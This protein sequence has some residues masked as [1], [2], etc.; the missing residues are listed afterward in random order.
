MSDVHGQALDDLAARLFP[1]IES[2]SPPLRR[3]LGQLLG[4][5]LP[6]IAQHLAADLPRA[7]ALLGQTITSA[8]ATAY[9]AAIERARSERAGELE[10]LGQALLGTGQLELSGLAGS[11]TTDL[12][13][14]LALKDRAEPMGAAEVERLI[15]GDTAFRTLH[16][17]LEIVE[18]L[19]AEMEPRS[20]LAL[21]GGRKNK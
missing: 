5:H 17:L 14:S 19:S 1:A 18:K 2:L 16:Y 8:Q 20:L 9:A 11:L 15:R 7:A 4:R 6:A 13:Q 21:R 12:R 10:A 3:K